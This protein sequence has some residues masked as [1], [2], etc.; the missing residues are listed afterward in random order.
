MKKIILSTLISCSLFLTGCSALNSIQDA[1]AFKKG[2]KVTEQQIEKFK[3]DKKSTKSSIIALIGE[4]QQKTDN[5][6]EYHYQQINHVSSN[7][8]VV[9]IFVF[10]KSN[11]LIEVKS[12]NGS[13]YGNPLTGS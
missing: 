11:N 2:T 13:F 5:S 9:T 8:D 4:P 3:A 10:D 7:V 6:I 1:T 12:R